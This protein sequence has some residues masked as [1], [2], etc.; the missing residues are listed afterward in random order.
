[1]GGRGFTLGAPVLYPPVLTVYDGED[2]D[3][4]TKSE[5][6]AGRELAEL[7]VVMWGAKTN[8]GV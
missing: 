6:A 3:F 8:E 1:L 5:A 2:D 7:G 4:D